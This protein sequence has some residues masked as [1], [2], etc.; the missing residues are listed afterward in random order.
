MGVCKAGV[1]MLYVLS[2]LSPKFTLNCFRTLTG[3]QPLL[4]SWSKTQ[5]ILLG[6][7]IILI[8][9][10]QKNMNLH[11]YYYFIIFKYFIFHVLRGIN[12]IHPANYQLSEKLGV[13]L[14]VRGESEDALFPSNIPLCIHSYNQSH[15]QLFRNQSDFPHC[16]T[17]HGT[18][19]Q[20]TK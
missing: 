15:T 6:I 16:T 1:T 2:C 8:F 14:M 10:L 17:I 3:D 20:F 4:Q 5:I 19:F 11:N 9:F 7:F 18:F 12:W 13:A